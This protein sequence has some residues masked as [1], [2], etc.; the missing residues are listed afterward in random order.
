MTP[1]SGG[2]LIPLGSFEQH[3][4]HLPHSVDTLVATAVATRVA[5]ALNAARGTSTWSVTEALA[6]GE[7]G[8]HEGFPETVSLPT[9]TLVTVL[10]SLANSAGRNGDVV[11]LIN[12]HG[13]NL[14]ALSQAGRWWAESD[15]KVFWVPCSPGPALP[16]EPPHDA[17]AGHTETS[18]MLHLHPDLVDMSRARKGNTTP[19]VHLMEAMRTAGVK[20]VSDNGVLGDPSTASATLGERYLREMVSGVIRRIHDGVTNQVACLVDT[21]AGF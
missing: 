12:A 2:I 10:T 20:A 16:G 14:Q 8:E 15:Q 9:D 11:I 4:P 21:D 1:I 18:M 19:V 5:D 7:S 17:H 3:G 6:F 13:G